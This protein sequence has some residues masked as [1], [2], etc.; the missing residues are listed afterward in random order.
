MNAIVDVNIFEDLEDEDDEEIFFQR[1]P[2][3]IRVRRNHLDLWDDIDFRCRFRLNKETVLIIHRKIEGRLQATWNITR[4][5][6]PLQQ[7]LLILRFYAT[8]NVLRAVGDFSDVCVA[9]ACRIVRRVSIALA[10]LRPQYIQMPQ[11]RREM[12]EIKMEFFTMFN[13]PN[14]I[15]CIDGTHIRIQ[16]PGGEN[17]EVF[18]NR[19]GYFSLNVQVVCDHKMKI[20]DIVARWPGSA[21][22]ATIFSHSNLYNKF[23]T[24]QFS[25]GLLLGDSAY[26]AK[27][28]LL[29]PVLN[30]RTQAE[31]RYNSAHIRTRNIIERVFGVWKR[32]FPILSTGMKVQMRTI[33]AIIVATAV[34]HNIAVDENDEDPPIEILVPHDEEIVDE[35]HV[36]N[37]RGV[38]RRNV[39]ITEYFTR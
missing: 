26:P 33:Q 9:T 3:S 18:R 39:I 11:N 15:G 8:G 27:N 31:Q 19:K 22:D 7:L 37:N 12:Q 35:P 34:L 4:A 5:L 20:R 28:Y 13:F 2:Y 6:S 25:S 21:H 29:T 30:P 24:Q 1:R 10:L 16:S 36:Q 32:R 23:E 14:V 38:A 17:A